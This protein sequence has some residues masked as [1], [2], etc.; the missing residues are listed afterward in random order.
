MR[1][2]ATLSALYLTVASLHRT[3]AIPLDANDN[4]KPLVYQI[5]LPVMP[6]GYVLIIRPQQHQSGGPQAQSPMALCPTIQATS[7][8]AQ[9]RS[10]SSQHL[11]IGGRLAP[12]GEL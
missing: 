4:G 6:D 9:P 3:G 7:P 11:T 12:Y 5:Q 1:V 8:P 2:F 10:D